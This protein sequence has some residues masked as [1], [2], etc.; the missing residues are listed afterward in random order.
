METIKISRFEVVEVSVHKNK[1]AVKRSCEARDLIGISE[2]IQCTNCGAVSD[3]HGE[4]WR[5]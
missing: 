1:W 4:T 5:E 2:G 3:D